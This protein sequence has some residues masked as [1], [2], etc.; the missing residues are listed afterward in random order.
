MI[1]MK[2]HLSTKETFAQWLTTMYL[3]YFINNLVSS[4]APG[5]EE[6]HTYLAK[7][8]FSNAIDTMV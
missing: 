6:V 1:N 5:L 2:K 3:F 8:R 4:D 7:L